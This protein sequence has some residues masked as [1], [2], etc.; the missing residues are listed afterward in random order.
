MAEDSYYKIHGVSTY[1]LKAKIENGIKT[2]FNETSKVLD[3]VE[4]GNPES[5]T[6]YAMLKKEFNFIE[7]FAILPDATF[8]NSTEKIKYFGIN[9]STPKEV[10]KNIEV[11]FYNS[12]NDFAIMLKTKEGEEVY[13]YKTTGEGKSFEENFQYMKEQETKSTKKIEE[14]DI[15]KIPFIKINDEISYDEL[16]GKAI[17]GTDWT[18]AQALQNIDFELNNVGGSVKSEALIELRKSVETTDRLANTEYI[19][20]SDFILYLKEENKNKPY[21]ALK[22]DNNNVLVAG[23]SNEMIEN[24]DLDNNTEKPIN[25]LV[26][27]IKDDYLLGINDKN[28]EVIVHIDEN[29]QI[30]GLGIYVGDYIH[31]YTSDKT[32]ATTYPLQVFNVTKIVIDE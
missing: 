3:N 1:E 19:F 9:S 10:L 7:K 21:L 15:L 14:G 28:E 2:K 20:D 29:T 27:E 16:C 32:I 8:G 23:E 26:K 18:I 13:L 25:V 17:K 6:L 4:W 31:V 11:L 12:K 5:Y 24:T 30:I 22:V